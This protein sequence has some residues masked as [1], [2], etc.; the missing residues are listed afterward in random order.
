MP[1][2]WI[3]G[4]VIRIAEN[5]YGTFEGDNNNEEITILPTMVL[6]YQLKDGDNIS[7]TTKPSQDGTKTFITE[8]RTN[9]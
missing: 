6:K 8:I 9:S 4:Q 3:S 5:G 7:V 1:G 2:N